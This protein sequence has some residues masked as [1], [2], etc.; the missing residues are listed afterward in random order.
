[1]LYLLLVNLGSSLFLE[2]DFRVSVVGAERFDTSLGLGLGADWFS[3]VPPYPTECTTTFATSPLRFTDCCQ[4]VC[5][6]CRGLFLDVMV[7]LPG[8]SQYV[9]NMVISIDM[10][11]YCRMNMISRTRSCL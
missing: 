8:V 4:Q 6:I 9:I 3:N 2:D 1:M 11:M 5:L 10:Y 7:L